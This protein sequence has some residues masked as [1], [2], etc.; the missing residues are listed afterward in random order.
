MGRVL[1]CGVG[2]IM[3]GLFV[4]IL[5]LIVVRSSYSL[6]LKLLAIVAVVLPLIGF[7]V[8]VAHRKD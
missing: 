1:G 6:P 3:I 7:V 2:V 5:V 8:S 4:R